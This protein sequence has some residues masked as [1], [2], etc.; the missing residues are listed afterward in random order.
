MNWIAPQKVTIINEKLW[1]D[2]IKRSIIDFNNCD[3]NMI[4]GRRTINLK[5]FPPNKTIPSWDR[6]DLVNQL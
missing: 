3:M 5:V 4:A 1:F 6:N 2:A